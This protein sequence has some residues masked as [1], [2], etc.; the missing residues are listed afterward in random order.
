MPK[1]PVKTATKMPP[2]R[3]PI[4]PVLRAMLQKNHTREIL[5]PTALYAIPYS[6]GMRSTLIT[7]GRMP[8]TALP[9]T[10]LTA[11][12]IITP[13]SVLRATLPPVGSRQLS[14]M[15]LP[16]PQIVWRAIPAIDQPITTQ[17]SAHPVTVPLPGC[18]PASTILSRSTTAVHSS[19]ASCAIL[20][21]IIQTTHVMGVMSTLLPRSIRSMR[22]SQT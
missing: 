18:R 17:V 15:R 22:V 13:D 14:I 9:A 2:S 20:P 10:N 16:A 21:P 3:A 8:R 19:D 4:P 11:L 12:P 5:G 7:V 1:Q 6:A